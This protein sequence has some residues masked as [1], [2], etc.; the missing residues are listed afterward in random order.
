MRVITV[1]NQ[2]GGCGKTTVAINLAASIAREARR[3]LLLDLDPQGHCA[4]GTAVPEEQVDLSIADCLTG[5]AGGEP[6]DLSRIVWQIAPNLD[7]APAKADLS[8][9]EATLAGR[10]DVDDLV[11]KLLVAGG[12]AYEYCVLDCPPHL[13]L[14]MRNGLR[15]A[16]EVII[17]VDTGFFSLHGL[18][19]QLSTIEELGARFGNRPGVRVLPNQYDVRT[20][21]AREVLA[22][23]R[24]KFKGVVFETIVN[25]NTKLKE[26]ASFG[27]PITEF[28]PNSM[29]AKDFQKLAREVIATEPPRIATPDLIAHMEKL[30]EE[31][32]R[33][34]ATTTTLVQSRTQELVS[35]EVPGRRMPLAAE[36]VLDSRTA[37]RSRRVPTWTEL[38]DNA[39]RMVPSPGSEPAR[40]VVSKPIP[41]PPA[42]RPPQPLPAASRE[43]PSESA[44]PEGREAVSS[45]GPLRD[46]ARSDLH[47][48]IDRQIEAIYG[49]RQEGEVVVFRSRS[50]GASEIQLAGDFNDW[51]PHTTPMRRVSDGEFEARLKLPRGRY[52]YRLVVDGRWLHDRFNPRVET[53]EYGELNSVV[54]V[55]Q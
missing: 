27:Q 51:M 50:E 15:A 8:K 3:T 18:T 19:R 31:A 47:E 34:L 35:A 38:D 28:A 33:L 10:E 32:E 20:K 5:L 30:S 39:K 23:L 46:F 17:P 13:G 29:G 43:T 41:F 21:L 12:R 11:H 44:V 36:E 14:L 25:F 37:E 53:N 1:A 52:R 55:T 22:E 42:P 6:I 40:P 54:E 49:V 9:L 7:L 45:R 16:D 24:A 48:T 26:G 4:L 2:K